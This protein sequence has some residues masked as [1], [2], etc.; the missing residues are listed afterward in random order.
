MDASFRQCLCR[1]A[2]RRSPASGHVA[3]A[4][5]DAAGH[6]RR[7]GAPR[8]RRHR[9]GDDAG[10]DKEWRWEQLMRFWGSGFRGSGVL[11]FRGSEVLGFWGSGVLGFWGSVDM[12]DTIALAD[13]A[14]ARLR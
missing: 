3:R 13:D 12:M 2:A 7:G 5:C 8:L 4:Y 1:S 10:G 6:M 9:A 14:W 11:G